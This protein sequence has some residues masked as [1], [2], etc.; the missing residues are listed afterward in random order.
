MIILYANSDESYKQEKNL[1]TYTLA[2]I[3]IY[4]Y[5]SRRFSASDFS[6]KEKGPW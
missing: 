3:H 6:V 5:I 4:M 2:Y 1:L